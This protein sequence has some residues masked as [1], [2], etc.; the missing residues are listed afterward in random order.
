MNYLIA[1]KIQIW[2]SSADL[3]VFFRGP[4]VLFLFGGVGIF[5]SA[6]VLSGSLP[7]R[8]NVSQ[9]WLRTKVSLYMLEWEVQ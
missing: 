9:I 6:T 7:I 3:F 5:L 2:K 8:G 1:E 4:V